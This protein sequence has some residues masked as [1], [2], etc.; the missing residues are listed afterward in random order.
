MDYRY[1][2]QLLERYWRRETTLQEEEI[3]RAFFS[4]EEVPVE[5][6]AYRDLFVAQREEKEEAVLGADFDDR[7]MALIEG[8]KPVRA[9]VITMRQRL[10]PLFKAAAVV[11]ITLTLGNAMQMAFDEPPT[12]TAEEVME[13]YNKAHRGASVAKADTVKVDTLAKDAAVAAPM[14]K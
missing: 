3:L 9:Q 1:I 7:M 11:A 6:L 8:Q 13:T 10:S 5:L 2:E 12:M 4:Q 14:V